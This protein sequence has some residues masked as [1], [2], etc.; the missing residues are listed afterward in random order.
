MSLKSMT[1]YGRAEAEHQGRV[2]SVEVRS[3]NNRFLDAKIKLPRNYGSLEDTIRRKITSYHMRG[4]VDLNLSVS[5][6]FSDL[7]R[8]GV[9][10]QLARSYH[11]SLLELAK[12][13]KIKGQPDLSMLVSLPDVITR[14]QQVEDLD[15]VWPRLEP[16]IDDALEQCLVMRSAEA[17]ALV[18]DLSERLELFTRVLDEIEQNIGPILQQRQE[19]MQERLE[20]LLATIELDPVRLAQEVAVLADKSDVTEELVRLR[21]HIDQFRGLLES[22]EPVGRKLDF[23]IQEFLREVNTIASKISDA[24]TA[25]KTVTLKSELEKMREQVQNIE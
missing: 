7:V 11:R 4:R 13:L 22:T 10:S 15:Q 3:V 17:E 24:E 9:D 23:L 6:D 2:W 14:E 25:H 16:L 12:D 1:G 18:R 20:R 21:S 5:G 8:I 19:A